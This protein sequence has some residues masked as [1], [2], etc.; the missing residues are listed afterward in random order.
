MLIFQLTQRLCYTHSHSK[1]RI[2]S[3]KEL[4]HKLG[5]IQLVILRRQKPQRNKSHLRKVLND[6]YLRMLC[7]KF[8]QSCFWR[9][10][11]VYDNVKRL[12]HGNTTV[13]Q[14]T[15][16]TEAI[17]SGELLKRNPWIKHFLGA[18]KQ[19]LRLKQKYT[20]VCDA[21]SSHSA[22]S[23]QSILIVYKHVH[24]SWVI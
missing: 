13:K 3:H 24:N 23:A 1:S 2:L 14:W 8:G 22:T 16:L 11:L 4:P 15:S 6:R 19:P 20:S 17:S 12:R 10:L 5:L 18:W 21:W 7:A 9:R